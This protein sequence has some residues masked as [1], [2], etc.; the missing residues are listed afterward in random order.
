MNRAETREREL[1]LGVSS[2]ID[3]M[4]RL[5]GVRGLSAEDEMQRNLSDIR[6]TGYLTELVKMIVRLKKLSEY[7]MEEGLQ[8]VSY[9]MVIHILC[10][11]VEY[12]IKYNKNSQKK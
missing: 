12:D 5:Y 1:E 9:D 3:L 6:L 7:Y 4:N 2:T 8:D 11:H 10:D